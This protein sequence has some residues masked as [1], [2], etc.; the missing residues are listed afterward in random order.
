MI[1]IYVSG[2]E[3]T[4][5]KLK[6]VTWYSN[7]FKTH[8]NQSIIAFRRVLLFKLWCVPSRDCTDWQLGI[9][10]KNPQLISWKSCATVL[11]YPNLSGWLR[12]ISIFDYI[13]LYSTVAVPNSP[14]L[15]RIVARLARRSFAVEEGVRSCPNLMYL[16][17][18][19]F[20][21]LKRG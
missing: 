15:F 20:Q 3:L 17:L 2:R 6:K 16:D 12:H 11:N 10:L 1:N 18:K 9:K 8:Q 7:R 14:K 5:I 4:L 21:Q 19:L 13:L